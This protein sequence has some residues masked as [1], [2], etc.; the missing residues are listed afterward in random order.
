MD[1]SAINYRPI[2]NVLFISKRFETLIERHI[3][4]HILLIDIIE[5]KL[6]S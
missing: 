3:K 4:E 5:Q 6:L 1:Q 2:S